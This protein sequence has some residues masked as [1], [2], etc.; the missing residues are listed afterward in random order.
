ML[1]VLDAGHVRKDAPYLAEK[2]AAQM[3]R[4]GPENLASITTDGASSCLAAVN[5][6]RNNLAVGRVCC[7]AGSTWAT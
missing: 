5:L 3:A 4:I 6:L 7:G 1:E 2:R